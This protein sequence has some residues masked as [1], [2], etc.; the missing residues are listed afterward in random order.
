MPS[1]GV[2]VVRPT[3]NPNAK[4]VWAKA[5]GNG[6]STDGLDVAIGPSGEIVATGGYQTQIDF[7]AGQLAGF[8][9]LA[10]YLVKL[11]PQANVIWNHA[12]GDGSGAFG[13]GVAVDKAGFVVA[14]G[15]FSGTL[16]F[17]VKKLI[18]VGTN[19]NLFVSRFAP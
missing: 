14:T 15:Q 8:Q 11:D 13:A 12:F 17:G 19:P 1:P 16:D 5:Y 6:T 2:L 4:V 18:S 9:N 3:A 10:A 7:G